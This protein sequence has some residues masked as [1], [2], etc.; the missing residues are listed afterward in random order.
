MDFAERLKYF[1]YSFLLDEDPEKSYSLEDLELTGQELLEQLSPQFF[2]Y[3]EMREMV[4]LGDDQYRIYFK[5]E[6]EYYSFIFEFSEYES[7][8]QIKNIS[9][10]EKLTE[11]QY[12]KEVQA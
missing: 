7:G 6:S 2:F 4:P 5:Y 11:Q 9:A 3:M 10:A 8:W 12:N 1:Y